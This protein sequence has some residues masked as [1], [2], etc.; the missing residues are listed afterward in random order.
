ML[1]PSIRH[2]LKAVRR[3]ARVVRLVAI[4]QVENLFR[5]DQ[6]SFLLRPLDQTRKEGRADRCDGIVKIV[7]VL[8]QAR[9]VPLTEIEERA[10]T[11]LQLVLRLGAGILRE[12]QPL[13]FAK[14]G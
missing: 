12:M 5:R 2:G 13:S 4:A 11:R 1:S 8:M 10:R 14:R 7:L 6:R 3:A 9:P